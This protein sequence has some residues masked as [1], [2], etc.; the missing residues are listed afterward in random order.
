MQTMLLTRNP[1]IYIHPARLALAGSVLAYILGCN[2]K[3]KEW[4]DRELD[5]I[6]FITSTYTRRNLLSGLQSWHEYLDDMRSNDHYRRC[7]VAESPEL[8]KHCRCPGL[9]KYL[10]ALYTTIKGTED[11]PADLHA[12]GAQGSPPRARGRVLSR[13]KYNF[14]AAFKHNAKKTPTEYLQTVWDHGSAAAGLS[15]GEGI[16]KPRS[17]SSRPR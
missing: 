13:C 17:H 12:R 8:P 16:L 11:T 10:L 4:M 6:D 7:L 5:M 15:I 3:R 14:F 1:L 9:T 2:D